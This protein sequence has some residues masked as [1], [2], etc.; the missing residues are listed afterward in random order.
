[1]EITG[2]AFIAGGASGI[3]RACAI[4]LAKDG[5]AGI[6]IAD[7]NL[8][9]AKKVA[10]ECRAEATAAE[11]RVDALYVDV[12]R[13]DS[14]KAAIDHMLG[15]FGRVDYCIN[16][17]GIGVQSTSEISEANVAEFRRFLEVNVEGAFLLTRSFSAVM[18]RQEL[19][20]NGLNSSGR[21]P[22][23]GVI[24]NLGS[25]S[26]FVATPCM[27][28]Y[29]TAKHALIGLTKNAALDNAPYGIR[30][31]C[32]CPSWVDTPMIQRAKDGGVDIDS[33]VK[34]AVPLGRIAEPEELDHDVMATPSN[35][36]LLRAAQ[37]LQE[38]QLN[39][40]LIA[41]G[42]PPTKKPQRGDPIHQML[43]RFQ[44][45]MADQQTP[46]ENPDLLVSAGYISTG[47]PA[48]GLRRTVRHI[49]GHNAEGKGIFLSTDCGDHHRMMG[50]QQ[51]LAN[52]IY[53][54]K[55]T[56]VELNGD[57]D[58]KYA[59]ENEPP[60]HIHNGSVVRM[61][62]FAPNVMSP[63]HRAVSLDY[64]IVI[65]G[66]FKLI[67]DSGEE[68]IMRQGDVSVQ[69]ASAHKWHN[70]SG[71]GTLPGR[72]MWVLLDCNHVVHNGEKLEE[73]LGDLQPYYE[74]R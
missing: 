37:S 21:S 60:L 39:T 68:R 58:V 9:A 7:L 70:I 26:S 43:A 66:E 10:A 20:P 51:A 24:V 33:L 30:V 4:G 17:A 5:A 32:V 13:D 36:W 64:G 8:D 40:R 55:E 2:Y 14:L 49:T 59:K 54:T 6:A 56:P 27:V 16:C 73:F 71:N 63:M 12:T 29:T 23:G 69:R 74:G 53:S 45:L 38:D 25:A 35:V 48:P 28:Q 46:S 61:I 72:M 57:V 3:G 22:G 52:I 19:K 31:N 1:M 50:N 41:D 44:I 65:E 67:L 11:F 18:K 34:V 42:V 62:D 47:W 15:V